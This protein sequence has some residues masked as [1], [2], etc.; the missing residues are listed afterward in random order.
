MFR[1]GYA[2]SY[3]HYTKAFIK[4]EEAAQ[5]ENIRMHQGK[6]M[7]PWAWRRLHP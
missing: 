3:Q 7:D 1:T 4:D 5:K 6:Y 2:L